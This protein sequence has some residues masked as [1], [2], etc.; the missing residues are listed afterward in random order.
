MNYI[1]RTTEVTVLPDTEPLFSES[2]TTVK[3]V[4]EASGEFVEVQQS[5]GSGCIAINPEEW[6]A[7]REAIDKMISEC[8]GEQNDSTQ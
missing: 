2:A 8:R 4:D 6:P 1:T 5:A 3:I 7:L